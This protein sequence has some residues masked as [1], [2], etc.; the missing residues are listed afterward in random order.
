[1]IKNYVNSIIILF[2]LSLLFPS[3]SIS[4]DN[5]N[6]DSGTLEVYM[7][8]DEPVGGFQFDL[9]NVSIS[10][11]AGGLAASNGFLVSTS[12]TTILGFS[13]TGGTIPP[14]D[15]T[16][17][18]VTFNGSPDEICLGGVVVSSASGNAIDVEVG[19]CFYYQEDVLGCTDSDA[20]NYNPNA[21]L[22]DGSCQYTNDGPYFELSIDQTGESHLIILQ[23]SIIGLDVGDEI[24]VFDLDGVLYTVDAG[25]NPEYGEVL[26]GSGVWTGSGVSS[27]VFSVFNA[28]IIY[29]IRN[30]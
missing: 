12:S 2:T 25:Q 15:G 13:L 10:A 3:V 21:T 16:L 29:I 9:S 27:G 8:N 19:D 30:L 24:G 28:A 23:N 22:D 20:D 5:V 18:E 17:L 7:Q 1:M 4:I 26:V 6:L 11:A 14:G